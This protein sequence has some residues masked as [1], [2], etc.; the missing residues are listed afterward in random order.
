MEELNIGGKLYISARR[1]AQENKYHSDY[2]G[3]LIR[4]GKLEGHKVGR[5]WY[6]LDESLKAFLAKDAQ[7][8]AE[9]ISQQ[10]YAPVTPRPSTPPVLPH[11]TRMPVAPTSVLPAH[12]STMLT[13]A[14]SKKG[15]A[16]EV[17]SLYNEAV[18][19]DEE[20]APP[21]QTENGSKLP[22][23]TRV[24]SVPPVPVA[25]FA[26]T[27]KPSASRRIASTLF[28]IVVAAAAF[29]TTILYALGINLVLPR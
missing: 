22:L 25:R 3:Q 28:L 13:Y 14:K 16:V 29:S 17:R 27:Q 7:L 8:L 5:S 21:T 9:K 10:A 24:P 15:E 2:L 18:T 11:I 19:E 20:Q 26:A 23:A 1:A 12:D 6:I 4:A